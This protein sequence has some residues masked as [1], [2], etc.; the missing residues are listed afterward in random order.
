[1]SGQPRQPVF[2]WLVVLVCVVYAGLF[3]F[4]V[5][6]VARYYGVKKAPG[7]SANRNDGTGWFVSYVDDA[8][9]AAGRIQLGDRLLAING[10]QRHEV[11]G[12]FQWS[13]VDGGT[14]YRVDLDRAGERV[15][16]E[17]P[18]ILVPGQQLTPIYAFV[19]L[20]FVICGATLA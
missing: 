11:I 8:G 20:A 5:N 19:G 18:M 14:T 4:T 3:A 1:M 2:F 12:S 6:T 17:L 15:S 16:V 10:D 7:W 9:P 13:F